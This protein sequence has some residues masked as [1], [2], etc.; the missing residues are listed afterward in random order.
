[1]SNSLSIKDRRFKGF[2]LMEILTAM[3]IVSILSGLVISVF[4]S[5]N[6][7][8]KDKF[9]KSDQSNK[10]LSITEQFE[11]DND[12][13]QYIIQEG[14]KYLFRNEIGNDITYTFF[15]DCIIRNFQGSN[16]TIFVSNH[17]SN[18]VYISNQSLLLTQ[19]DLQ[20]KL[21]NIHYPITIRKDYSSYDLYMYFLEKE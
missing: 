1:M 2:T 3:V 8:Y 10:V 15:T 9:K 12:N 19:L 17:L 6:M 18:R 20:I 13:S 14:E 11:S 4:A 5:L 21:N 7:I 16:D